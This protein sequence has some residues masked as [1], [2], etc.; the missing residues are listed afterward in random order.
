M[1][2]TVSVLVLYTDIHTVPFGNGSC[3]SRMTKAADI[4]P[5]T[6]EH[7]NSSDAI[8]CV[9]ASALHIH[10]NRQTEINASSYN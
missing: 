8:V 5:T 1:H 6:T 10:L 9:S 4:K 7:W 3:L 2:T